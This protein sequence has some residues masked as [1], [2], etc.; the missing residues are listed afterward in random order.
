MTTGRDRMRVLAHVHL[1]PPDH[2]AG[3]E[4][5]L[6]EA[7]V[8]LRK[9]GHDVQVVVRAS[10]AD[11]F[12]KVPV[13]T[14]DRRTID[15]LY[16]E[17]DIIVTHLDLTRKVIALNE[18]R[19]PLVHLVHNDRQL[20]AAKVQPCEAQLVVAN[21]R[22][23]ADAIDWQGPTLVVPPP[24]HPERYTV[25]RGG[26][27]TVTL[28]NLSQAKGA[29]LFW[30]LVARM[31]D[32]LFMGV[33]GG[34]G[35]QVIPRDIPAN[36]ILLPHSPSINYAYAQT[37][38]L[39]MPSEYESWGRVGIE[40]AAS[41]IPTIAHPTPGLLESLGESGT[42]VDRDDT[43]GWV[44]AI[45]RLQNPTRYTV[46]SAQARA[47]SRELDPTSDILRL[48][49]AMKETISGWRQR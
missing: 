14:E 45:R 33:V 15:G 5:Y 19:R 20:A 44:D 23:I 17:A 12:D 48:E 13:H 41:G 28:V 24:V 3:A 11:A 6:H 49:A 38:I 18:G 1:Y 27:Q 22:W 7:L 42:F 43:A 16:D 21:S 2:C 10:S 31:P 37:S 4:M 34:Y 35:K 8:G 32:T 29:D 36:V 30:R 47:R 40:G 9:R 26:L 25:R 46:K 39:L